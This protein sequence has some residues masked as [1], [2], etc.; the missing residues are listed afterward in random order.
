MHF[1]HADGSDTEQY[2]GKTGVSDEQC[3][4]SA[5]L[6][7]STCSHQTVQRL[8]LYWLV[9][10]GNDAEHVHDFIEHKFCSSTTLCTHM[11]N[12]IFY[13]TTLTISAY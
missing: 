4:H 8:L 9:L 10:I 6:A 2:D 1:R 12:I 3:L 11:L 5:H 13:Y 7:S